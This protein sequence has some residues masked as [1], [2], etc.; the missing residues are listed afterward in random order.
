MCATETE[1]VQSAVKGAGHIF[2]EDKERSWWCQT[3]VYPKDS[4][5]TISG[6]HRQ[7]LQV[8]ASLWV[9]LYDRQVVKQD[10]LDSLGM[11]VKC[12]N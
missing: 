2:V 10:P 12:Q 3:V 5:I 11:R 1:Y 4:Q 6:N 8:Y 9:S 7:V